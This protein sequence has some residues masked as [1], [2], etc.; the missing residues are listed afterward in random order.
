MP[1]GQSPASVKK[2]CRCTA[3]TQTLQA[4]SSFGQ[5]W[6]SRWQNHCLCGGPWTTVRLP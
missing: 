6:Q 1:A 5:L 3:V 4:K 2:C